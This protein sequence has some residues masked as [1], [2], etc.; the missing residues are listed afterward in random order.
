[1][2]HILLAV[3]ESE[4]SKR[5]AD[6]VDHLFGSDVVVTAVMVARKPVLNAVPAPSLGPFA[7]PWPPSRASLAAIDRSVDEAVAREE[8]VA[9]AVALLQAPAADRVSVVFG[10]PVQAI[11]RLA[12]DLDAGLIVVGSNRRGRLRRLSGRSVPERLA[13]KA[14][15]PVL[16]VR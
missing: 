4:G 3:D 11:S 9:G 13:R 6:F 5:A 15:R 10:E 1:M 14:P 12:E 8:V 7:W 16:I 2:R